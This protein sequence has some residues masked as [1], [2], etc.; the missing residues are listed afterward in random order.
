[1]AKAAAIDWKIENSINKLEVQN[2]ICTIRCRMI[3]ILPQETF[4]DVSTTK[5]PITKS[6]TILVNALLWPGYCD[7]LKY[8]H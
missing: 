3:E 7:L 8:D 5:Y 1:M 6:F 4:I 2:M